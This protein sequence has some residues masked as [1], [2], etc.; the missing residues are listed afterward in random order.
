MG[1]VSIPGGEGPCG[2][3]EGRHRVGYGQSGS[4]EGPPDDV[5]QVSKNGTH[6]RQLHFNEGPK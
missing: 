4:P 3:R 1:A 6:R 5:F 2:P